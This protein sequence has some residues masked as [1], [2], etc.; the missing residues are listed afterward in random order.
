MRAPNSDAI[1]MDVAAVNRHFYAALWST[2]ELLPP[3]RFNTW[4]LIA[5]LA[6]ASP[7]RLELGPGM[8]P[9]LPM[10]GTCFI[11][12]SAPVIKRLNVLGV[13]A[14]AAELTALPFASCLFE[15]VCAF[16]VIEHIEDDARVFGEI[17]RVL[18]DNGML[19]FSVPLHRASWTEFD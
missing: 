8:R 17:S 12:I 3:E 2:T 4:P 13:N 19:V 5:A 7:N 18:K 15:L 9:R 10:D 6:A 14:V 16:D 11:D 1:G